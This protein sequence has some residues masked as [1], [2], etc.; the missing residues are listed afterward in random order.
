M[1]RPE[2]RS[3]LHPSLNVPDWNAA[4]RHAQ[5]DRIVARAAKQRERRKAAKQDGPRRRKSDR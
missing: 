5:A 1:S 2:L 3:T 4:E